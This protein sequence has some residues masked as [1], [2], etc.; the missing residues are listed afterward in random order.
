M[1]VLKSVSKRSVLVFWILEVNIVCTIVP[2]GQISKADFLS[3][4]DLIIAWSLVFQQNFGN[5]IGD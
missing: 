4:L 5:G 1:R 3:V 2:E